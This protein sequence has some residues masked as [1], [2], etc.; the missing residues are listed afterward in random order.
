MLLC[1][2]LAAK[3]DAA[4]GEE[5]YAARPHRARK[6]ARGAAPEPRQGDAP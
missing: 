4:G 3:R 5:L 1:F 6:G 2:A